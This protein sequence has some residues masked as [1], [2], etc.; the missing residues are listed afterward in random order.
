MSTERE[1]ACRRSRLDRRLFRESPFPIGPT[2]RS[3][4]C[5]RS[6]DLVQRGAGG[7]N[8][9][10]RRCAGNGIAGPVA[11]EIKAAPRTMPL[12]PS[13]MRAPLEGA[14]APA[15]PRSATGRTCWRSPSSGPRRTRPAPTR[16]L[17]SGRSRRGS[18]AALRP[19]RSRRPSSCTCV[20]LRRIVCNS[21]SRSVPTAGRG[22]RL[23]PAREVTCRRGIWRSAWPCFSV[24]SHGTCNGNKGDRLAALDHLEQWCQRK[25]TPVVSVGAQNETRGTANA[26]A[27]R[28]RVGLVPHVPRQTG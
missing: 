23:A 22:R 13:S 12:P 5:R 26:V 3:V 17:L 25:P 21:S 9:D 8:G 28:H 2:D 19:C 16:R 20:S 1:R 11:I 24:L 4:A 7:G 14:S 18:G 27:P 6:G 10:T 15:S